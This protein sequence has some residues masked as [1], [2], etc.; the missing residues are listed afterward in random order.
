[1]GTKLIIG[2]IVLI[3]CCILAFLIPISW[4]EHNNCKGGICPAPAERRINNM[5]DW[6]TGLDWYWLVAILA[7]V[8]AAIWYFFIK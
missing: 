8:A 5:L 4:Q 2:I 6:L 7:G 3:I 1:V